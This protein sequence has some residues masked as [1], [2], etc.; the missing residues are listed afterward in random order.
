MSR[1]LTPSSWVLVGLNLGLLGCRA[2]PA[3]S[4]FLGWAALLSLP[5]N[6]HY[7]LQSQEWAHSAQH[8][9]RQQSAHHASYPKLS[10]QLSARVCACVCV[11]GY[12]QSICRY[13]ITSP[14]S[15]LLGV[16]VCF[17]MFNCR[18]SNLKVCVWAAVWQLRAHQTNK[19]TQRDL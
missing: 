5:L 13:L 8:K 1:P 11:C 10:T 12:D 14:P 2:S 4:S 9:A 19:Q 18:A 16:F 15:S 7:C 17:M 3:R 6:P